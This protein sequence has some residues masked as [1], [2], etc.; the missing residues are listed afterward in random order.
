MSEA[1]R[2]ELNDSLCIV[3]PHEKGFWQADVYF[4]GWHEGSS[5]DWFCTGKIGDDRDDIISKVRERFSSPKIV[6]GI[7]GIC[8]ECGEEFFLLESECECGGIIDD[9]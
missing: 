1:K 9:N 7:T 2:D 5:P 8:I 3:S 4:N 6:D